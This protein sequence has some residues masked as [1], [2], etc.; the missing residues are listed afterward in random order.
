VFSYT[1]L[2]RDVVRIAELAR[3][4]EATVIS[5]TRS[6]TALAAAS[7]IVIAID[8]QENTFVYAPMV[9]RLAHL[10][11]VDVLATAVALR[12]GP[13]GAEVIRRVKRAVSDEWLIDPDA[14]VT[15]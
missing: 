2:V 13:P 4:Q 11:V 5:V 3:R 12:S 6:A 7:D 8:T 15:T 14:E 1:G 9:T 10:A